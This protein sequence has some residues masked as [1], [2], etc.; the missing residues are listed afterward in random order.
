MT[1]GIVRYEDTCPTCGAALET[2][3]WAIEDNAGDV[4]AKG[5]YD[6]MMRMYEEMLAD[7][8]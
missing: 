3:L 7:A 8:D 5:T 2:E 4:L 1:L 6:D